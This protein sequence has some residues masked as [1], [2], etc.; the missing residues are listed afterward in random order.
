MSRPD[1]QH[2]SR[3]RAPAVVAVALSAL[4]IIVPACGGGS[5]S[6]NPVQPTPV[7][8]PPPPS[9][10]GTLRGTVVDM[11]SGAGVEGATLTFNLASG[12]VAVTS[13]GG[14]A[15][16]LSQPSSTL[17]TIPVEIA[18]PGFV[19][20]RTYVRWAVGIRDGIAIDI[21]RESN[22]FSL[23]YYQALVRNLFSEP[24]KPPEPLRRWTSPPDFYVHT[25]N[26][27]TGTTLLQSEID[28]LRDVIQSAV[29]QL[30]GGRFG[31]GQIEFGAEARE[32][33]PG[34]INVR[35]IHDPDSEYCG[36]AYVGANPGDI[37]LNYGVG[38]CGATCGGFAPRTVAHEIGH[39]MG[40]FH[41]E[42][43]TV[44][45]TNWFGSQCGVTAFSEAERHHAHVAY[46]R[47]PGNR[48]PDV[49]PPSAPFLDGAAG[50][51]VRIRCR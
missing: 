4:A 39:A 36:R 47:L 3:R 27:R 20:R 15:W 46:S 34:V 23:S 29:P 32:P 51:P 25:F 8:P 21:I 10:A 12:D 26:P 50:T 9:T 30:T 14:G 40:F 22:P 43:G 31:A 38:G 42:I 19:T 5:G 13:S 37:E 48:D 41:V 49:D 17:T 44:L 45:N 33:R 1:L 7:T 28:L 6:P 11:L 16:E 35:F 18:A 2:S 24:D